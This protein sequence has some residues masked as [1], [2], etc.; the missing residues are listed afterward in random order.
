MHVA[1]YRFEVLA[2]GFREPV[3]PRVTT[4]KLILS[5]ADFVF[6][7][8]FTNDGTSLLTVSKDRSAKR[9]T[10]DKEP[11]APPSKGGTVKKK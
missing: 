11:P 1:L 9:K 3:S 2:V 8:A 7:V 10:S 5:G 6:D 4:E